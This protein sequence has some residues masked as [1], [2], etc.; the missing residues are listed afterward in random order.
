[1]E[2][3][4]K[5]Q[6]REILVDLVKNNT[7][8]KLTDPEKFNKVMGYLSLDRYD[9]LTGENKLNFYLIYYGDSYDIYESSD[10]SVKSIVPNVPP[11]IISDEEFISKCEGK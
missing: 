8:I 2:G 1:M 3:N 6:E 7:V 11:K 9:Y 5:M 10:E 4:G